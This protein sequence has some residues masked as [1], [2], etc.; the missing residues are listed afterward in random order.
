MSFL[1]DA[2]T[3]IPSLGAV[4]DEAVVSFDGTTVW[5]LFFSGTG[6]DAADVQDVD[7]LHCA[8]SQGRTG[9][10]ECPSEPERPDC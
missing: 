1:R 2:S 8:V 5:A 10:Q 4:A 3:T 6:L 9:A 7:V